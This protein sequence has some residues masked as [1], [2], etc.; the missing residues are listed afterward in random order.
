VLE[1]VSGGDLRQHLESDVEFSRFQIQ[2]YLAEIVIALR[3]L[4]KLD[5]IYRDLKPDNILIDCNGHIKLADFGLS[6][7]IDKEESENHY[8]LCG[9][10]EYIP[11][12]MLREEPQTFCVDWWALGIL[13]FRLLVGYL[14][15][16]HRS[17]RGL[18]ELILHSEVRIPNSLDEPAASL[19]RKLLVKNPAM[20]LGSIGT[21][22][23]AHPFFAG[24]CWHKVAKMEYDPPFKP[25]VSTPDSID[26]YEEVS[27][28][29]QPLDSRGVSGAE[30]TVPNFSFQN[31]SELTSLVSFDDLVNV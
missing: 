31:E 2:L 4:H 19:I 18:F 27:L 26:N 13:A 3:T 14:P 9:T 16:R 23:T 8:S 5:I 11:P 17:P 15:F 21:D 12:E 6:R 28:D 22:I 29:E 30:V 24:L 25:Y 20:R 10:H 1:F 7:Q